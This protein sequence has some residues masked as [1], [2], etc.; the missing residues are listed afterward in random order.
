[1]NQ[2]KCYSLFLSHKYTY[3]LKPFSLLECISSEDSPVNEV[4]S[5][6]APSL[7]SSCDTFKNLLL[8]PP[9]SL[10]SFPTSLSLYLSIY[11]SI[12]FRKIR[13]TKIWKLSYPLLLFPIFFKILICWWEL[14]AVVDWAI[15]EGPRQYFEPYWLVGWL[16]GCI[17]GQRPMCYLMFKLDLVFQ[18]NKWFQVPYDNH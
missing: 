15:P 13:A 5:S 4:N 12:Y 7:L 6:S 18:A 2:T 14:N 16:V 8:T 3:C 11:L 9:T 10:T 17:I 1:M